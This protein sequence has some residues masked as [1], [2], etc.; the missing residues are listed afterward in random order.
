[1]VLARKQDANFADMKGQGKGNVRNEIDRN[2][3]LKIS[4]G[5]KHWIRWLKK[6]V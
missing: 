4:L 1:M 6:C 5:L 2:E 3:E